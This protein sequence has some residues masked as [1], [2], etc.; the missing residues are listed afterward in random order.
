MP[1]FGRLTDAPASLVLVGVRVV[2]PGRASSERRDLAIHDGIV[3][4]P[5]RLPEDAERIAADGLVAAPGFCDLH[6]HLRQ[7]GSDGSET[8][9]SGTRAAARGGFTTV[10]AM[11][12]TDPPLDRPERVRALLD[13]SHDVAARVRVVAAAT[14]DRAGSEPVDVASLAPDVVALSDDGASV[15]ADALE[16][17]AP[18]LARLGIPL[19]EHAEDAALAGAAVMRD[20]AT[21]ARLG[22]PGWPPAAEL[23]VVERDLAVAE[24]IGLRIH[25]THLSTAASAA[26][27]RRARDRGVAVTCDV[28]PHHLALTDAWVAGERTFAWEEP[29][30]P[31]QRL[32]YDGRCRVNP[33]LASRQDALALLDA[34]AD[35]TIDAIATDHAPHPSERKLVPFAD[36]APGLIGLETALSIGLAAV[37]AGRLTLDGLIGALAVRP[38]AIIGQASGLAIGDVADLAVFDPHERWRVDPATLASASANTPLLGRELPGVVRLT[39]AAGRVTYRS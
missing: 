22:L 25:L 21:A 3:V 9:A 37:D 30:G 15:G 6:S 4:D 7:P 17:L 39:V 32:A 27:V 28:T 24:R 38:A 8:T 1:R 36:A 29:V 34:L 12:N 5:G 14:R 13:A 31:E 19:M 20:G 23:A 35:G 11:P 18:V 33:P 10:C 26:A 16:A 2:D